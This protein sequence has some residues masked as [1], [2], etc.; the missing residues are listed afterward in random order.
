METGK[1]IL[2]DEKRTNKAKTEVKV[3]LTVLGEIQN[4]FIVLDDD[5]CAK[6]DGT[7]YGP[8]PHIDDY[9]KCPDYTNR[10]TEEFVAEH[11][12]SKQCKHI[13]KAKLQRF[14]DVA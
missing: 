4:S 9:C 8:K 10:N 11:G 12:Y 7:I 5:N 2:S 14:G 6:Y 1:Q 13:I 3:Q